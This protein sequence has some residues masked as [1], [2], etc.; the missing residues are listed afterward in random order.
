MLNLIKEL[1]HPEGS[2]DAVV[3]EV[4]E[5]GIVT[6]T[7]WNGEI[8]NDCYCSDASGYPAE[9]APERFSLRP[10]YQEVSEDEWELTG[11]KKFF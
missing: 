9:D 5:L 10:V 8:W 3:M 1:G 4:E 11:F 7:G 2:L 6:L